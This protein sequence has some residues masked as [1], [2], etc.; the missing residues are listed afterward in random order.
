MNSSAPLTNTGEPF[1]N[2]GAYTYIFDNRRR[3][4]PRDINFFRGVFAAKMEKVARRL[5]P[6]VLLFASMDRKPTGFITKE[7]KRLSQLQRPEGV[8]VLWYPLHEHKFDPSPVW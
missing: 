3:K 8:E 2:A 4:L 6:D 7:L 5:L 1:R